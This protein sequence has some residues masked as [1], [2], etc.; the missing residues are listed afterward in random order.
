MLHK[1]IHIE[2]KRAVTELY[3]GLKRLR[4][5]EGIIPRS[6]MKIASIAA[7]GA[8]SSQIYKWLNEDLTDE[9]Q[10]SKTSQKGGQS[11]LSDDQEILVVGFAIFC[12]IS[13]VPVSLPSVISVN[14]ISI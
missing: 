8:T 2:R 12:R 5:E 6:P 7:G 4:E 10:A 9:G 14:H 13:L 1:H 3:R 11:L